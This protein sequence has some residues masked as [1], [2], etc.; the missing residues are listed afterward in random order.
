MGF[1]MATYYTT[2]PNVITVIQWTG[3]NFAEIEAAIQIPMAVKN[4]N[5]GTLTV[6]I[7]GYGDTRIAAT[8]DY[9]SISRSGG[10]VSTSDPYAS[11][12]SWQAVPSTNVEYT[13]S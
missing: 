8:G 11:D 2:R 3:S 4:N 13:V 7:S 12:P 5:D 10:S 6:T 9:I 1:L